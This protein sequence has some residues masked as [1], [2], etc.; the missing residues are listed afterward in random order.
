MNG[1]EMLWAL[2]KHLSTKNIPAILLTGRAKEINARQ[3]K[4]L[5]VKAII[6]KPFEPLTLANQILEAVN[7]A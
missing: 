5:G 4:H 2:Q 1:I 7:V 6:P 3:Y